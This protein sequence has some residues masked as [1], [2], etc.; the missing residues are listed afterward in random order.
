MT[1]ENIV[2]NQA[3]FKLIFLFLTLMPGSGQQSDLTW[4]FL[5]LILF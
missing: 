5:P 4:N 3:L 1:R 2:T